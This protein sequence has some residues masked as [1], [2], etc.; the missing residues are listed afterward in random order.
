MF[1]NWI[2]ILLCFLKK[3]SVCFCLPFL[4]LSKSENFKRKSRNLLLTM[5]GNSYDLDKRP[6]L[7]LVFL[8]H[9]TY[10]SG[11]GWIKTKRVVQSW[12]TIVIFFCPNFSQKIRFSPHNN[13]LCLFESLREPK[14]NCQLYLKRFGP[15]HINIFIVAPLLCTHS[16]FYTWLQQNGLHFENCCQNARNFKVQCREV[17]WSKFVFKKIDKI[18]MK[19]KKFGSIIY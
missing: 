17:L 11:N 12:Y 2:S 14:K 15:M 4:F 10:I 18:R 19:D 1:E 7:V 9:F 16:K 5:Y 8:Y 6:C 3:K 13:I